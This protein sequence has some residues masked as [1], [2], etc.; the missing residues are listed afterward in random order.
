[1]KTVT[2]RSK[3]C[4]KCGQ[5]FLPRS[6]SA[7]RCDACCTYTCRH[8]GKEFVSR[9]RRTIAFCSVECTNAWQETAAAKE[10]A[11][12]NTINTRGSGV[13]QRCITCGESFYVPGWRIKRTVKYCC[14][15]C[16]NY[17]ADMK[18]INRTLRF[19]ANKEANRLE[20][21]GRVILD[22]LGVPFVEQQVIGGKFVVDAL[23]PEHRVIIQWDGDFWHANPAL[24]ST[25][26]PIQQTN[27]ARDRSCNAYLAKCG[28]TVL[29][30]WET[31]VHSTPSTVA[32]AIREC[33]ASSSST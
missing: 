21:A 15:A 4:E 13:V 8:C 30:F 31:D 27:T 18:G 10:R 5:P 22:T 17:H 7:R 29:R 14:H 28:Y 26:H 23:L 33:L 24:F 9:R 12:R 32:D 3:T 11:R 2:D 16:R 20:A 1:M 6:N 25:L 19:P